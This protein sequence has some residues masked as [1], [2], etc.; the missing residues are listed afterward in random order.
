MCTAYG[1]VPRTPAEQCSK[2][3]EPDSNLTSRVR[4][5]LDR[6]VIFA[7]TGRVAARKTIEVNNFRTSHSMKVPSGSSSPRAAYLA[8]AWL[9]AAIAAC[10]RPAFAQSGTDASEPSP[11]QPQAA[12]FGLGVFGL[13]ARA[14]DIYRGYDG[15]AAIYPSLYY[16]GDRL[17]FD[18]NELSY[19]L[20]RAKSW[21]LAPTLTFNFN[22]YEGTDSPSLRGM[23]KRSDSVLL[24]FR[25]AFEI[26]WLESELYAAWDAGG[27]RG[28]VVEFETGVDA[29]IGSSAFAY[30]NLG[31]RYTNRR[32]NNYFFGVNAGEA[33]ASRPAYTSG[34]SITPTFEIGVKYE[35]NSNWVLGLE[36]EYQA[37][38]SAITN[39]PIVGRKSLTQV[40]LGFAYRWFR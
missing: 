32:Y 13:S 8:L 6:L 1:P 20:L 7:L 30:A 4:Q 19:T 9:L 10:G 26:G 38:P 29:P 5:T 35:L 39:S 23:T 2:L 36:V 17:T 16:R 18:R 33:I 11:F 14:A 28:A 31:A 21:S 15:G 27:S 37:F 34:S 12:E 22:G 25:S 40:Q 24:G 3:N